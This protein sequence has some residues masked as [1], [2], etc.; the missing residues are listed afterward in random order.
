METQAHTFV[1]RGATKLATS[2]LPTCE[3]QLRPSSSFSVS[4]TL[5]AVDASEYSISG[6]KVG[7]EIFEQ[8][9]ESPAGK[10][11]S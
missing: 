10:T 11:I 2:P 3:K 8:M 9:A 6:E 7:Q 5:M 4:I 1:A